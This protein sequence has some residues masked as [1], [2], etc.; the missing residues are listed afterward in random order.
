MPE[1]RAG[2]R[3]NGP[4]RLRIELDGEVRDVALADPRP[5]GLPAWA[6]LADDAL[7]LDSNGRAGIARLAPAP[8]VEAAIRHAGHHGS[9]RQTVSAP[10]PGQV[11]ELRVVE[12]DE[13]E[14]GQ[15]LLVLEAMK[16]ENAV[17][18][19]GPARVERLLVATGEQVQRGQHLVE[20]G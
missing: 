4:P 15:V 20:L 13:V 17:V 16:M 2:F 6:A 11:L 9:G 19:P 8:T 18:A 14:A 12:G 3:L 5:A 10:M 7:V 1:P